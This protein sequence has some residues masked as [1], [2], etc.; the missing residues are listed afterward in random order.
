MLMLEELPE[1]NRT[2]KLGNCFMMSDNLDE[3]DAIEVLSLSDKSK[4][5]T[6][7]PFKIRFTMMLVCLSGS[8]R[9]RLQMEEFVM[10]RGD[11]I[12]AMEGTIGECI[13]IS[14]D[15]RLFMMA[16][17]NE[18]N[19]LD[20]G[21]K[22]TTEILTG[23]IKRPC[24][25]LNERETEHLKNIYELMRERL[26]D[27]NFAPKHELAANCMR[28]IF[29]YVSTYLVSD[30]LVRRKP[31][32]RNE[33]ILED[34]LKLVEKH[35]LEHRDLDFFSEKLFISTKYLS[36]VVSAA[37]GRSARNWI[38]M[39][40]ILEAKVLLKER[41]L[42]I[43]QISDRLNFANQS[44]FGTFFKRYTGMSPTDYRNM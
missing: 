41:E 30:E 2:M 35:S 28:T 15:A 36:K 40:V 22:P 17:S 7:T 26:D 8:M 34:F 25:R 33:R 31:V 5:R 3:S 39:R 38:C 20:S 23:I 16:F 27:E 14:S 1:S 42:S 29:S 12:V 13:S 18:F 6:E 24:F 9:L 32:T 10:S 21:L 4:I 43:Q 11:V 19:I 37:S 44:F